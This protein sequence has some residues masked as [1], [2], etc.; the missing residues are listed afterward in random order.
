MQTI[1]KLVINTIKI[2]ITFLAEKTHVFKQLGIPAWETEQPT[3][4]L[5]HSTGLV[6]LALHVDL[7]GRVLWLLWRKPGGLWRLCSRDRSRCVTTGCVVGI[8]KCSATQPP[9]TKKLN[10]VQ[11]QTPNTSLLKVTVVV[12]MIVAAGQRRIKL[13]MNRVRCV[14]ARTSDLVWTQRAMITTTM[15]CLPHTV[16]VS[17]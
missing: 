7:R 2:W 11:L 1:A 17:C 15:Y 5:I 12:M 4:H 6:Y 9:E 13:K 10:L 8:G 16:F 3:Q 14:F